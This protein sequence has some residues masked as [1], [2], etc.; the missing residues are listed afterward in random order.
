MTI[1]TAP[2]AKMATLAMLPPSMVTTAAELTDKIAQDTSSHMA[3]L[4][5][6]MMNTTTATVNTRDLHG[7]HV[8][9]QVAGKGTHRYGYGLVAHNLHHLWYTPGHLL[10]EGNI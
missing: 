10:L 8:P 2:N 5:T 3:T 1:I 6:T 9:M 7:F 4:L